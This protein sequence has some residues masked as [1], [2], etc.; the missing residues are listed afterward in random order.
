MNARVHWQDKVVR[1]AIYQEADFSNSYFDVSGFY[2]CDLSFAK[3]IRV[4]MY[5]SGFGRCDM[6]GVDFTYATFGQSRF[7]DVD[8]RAAIFKNADLT[9]TNFRNANLAYADFTGARN[10]E[11]EGRSEDVTFYETIMPDGSIRTDSV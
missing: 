1:G 2:E 10:W 3:F 6:P 11:I 7:T 4:R 8:L 5:E 9:E